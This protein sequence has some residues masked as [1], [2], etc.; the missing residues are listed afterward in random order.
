MS[1]GTTGQWESVKLEDVCEIVR[2]L[3]FPTTDKT[4]VPSD[5]TIACLRTTNVQREVEWDDLWFIPEKH[6]R[7]EAQLV[8]VGDVLI[9]TANS[10]ELVGKVAQVKNLPYTATLGAFIS[11]IRPNDHLNRS[12]VFYQLTTS[13]IQSEIRGMASTTTNIS[14]V[15]TGKLRDLQIHIAPHE[16]QSRIVAEIEKQFTRLDAATAALKRVQANLKRYR[17]SVLKAACKGHLV[18]TEAELARK[19]GRDY[20]P[21]DKLLLRILR[22]RRARW[23]ADIL[24]KMQASGKPPQ[25]DHW[26]QKY[27]EPS[28]PDTTDLPNLPE[29]WCWATV[30]QLSWRVQY[31]TSAKCS[32]VGDIPVLRMGNI[33]TDGSIVTLDSLKFLSKDHPE[34]PE[35]LLDV[36]DLIFNRTNSAELVGKSATYVGEP[37][38]CSFAS[39][40]IRVSFVAGC[41]SSFV[42]ACLNSAMGRKWIKSV[43]N[44]QVGQANVNGTKL[45]DFLVPL[46]P[47]AEQVRM[48]AALNAARTYLDRLGSACTTQ[49]SRQENLRQAILRNAF[50][51]QLV[52][53]DP[54]DEPASA[55]LERI[56]AGRASS[57]S[58]SPKRSMRAR[59]AAA[60]KETL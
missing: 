50:T 15:S 4:F 51:G 30:D 44:Q 6:V 3:A 37:E 45:K 29:G 41:D 59:R 39:Y 22:E 18:P 5:G 49:S 2:G 31:G 54:T 27:K 8:R 40:L 52:L 20:E 58:Q 38:L 19:E 25:D 42:S 12:F 55:L 1:E 9:S 11:L 10:F 17:A 57:L 53:Q 14:N 24:A 34:F 46:P 13:A 35:L 43:V 33:Q 23:E 26:K 21:A 60:S 16:E 36:G 28:A 7:H 47:K 48:T 56:R 32:E